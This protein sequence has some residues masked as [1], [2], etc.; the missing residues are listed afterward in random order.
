MK[1]LLF[2]LMALFLLGSSVLFAPKTTP[3]AGKFKDVSDSHWASREIFYLSGRG[4]ISGYP[5]GSFKPTEK[6]TRI[7]IAM[8]VQRE[9]KYNTANQPDPGLRDVPK[10]SKYHALV[11]AMMNNGLFTDIVKNGEF[12]LNQPVTRSEMAAILAK[13][14][15]LDG[16]S[17]KTFSDVPTGS[18][19]Y[20][21]I[22]AL[23]KNQITVGYNDGTFKPND[24]L[25][26]AQFSAM[27]AR[28]LNSAF[29]DS[30]VTGKVY[31][32]GWI[33]P[34]LKSSWNADPAVNYKTLQNELGFTNGGSRYDIQGLQGAIQVISQSPTSSYE[35]GI[36][37]NVWQDS[38]LTQSYRVPVV[39]KE[40]LKLYFSGDAT[41]VLGYLNSGNIPDD[42]TANGRKVHASVSGS[43]L[44]LEVGKLSNQPTGKVY[45]DGWVAPVLKSSWSSDPTKNYKTLQNELGFT[46][47]GKLYSIP[48]KTGA[49]QVISQGT[50]GSYEVA[51]Q[52]YVWKESALP[53][54]YRTPVVAKELFK[55][56]FDGEAT[57]VWNY[58]NSGNIPDS[59]TANGRSVQA[60][61]SSGRG[62]LTLKLGHKK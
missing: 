31:P 7:Q 40:L 36:K 22:Q 6:L 39:A 38:S 29:K 27:M 5:D 26:R 18:W 41:R 9:R 60:S 33:A 16:V 42:F 56:Y 19:S 24:T 50:G 58:L 1:K 3:A 43:G 59:F 25:T 11:A 53:Q 23:A 35:V 28:V 15:K 49:I 10:G 12:K 37:F 46:D 48:G 45:P 47:G 4:I 14:Y 17:G 54:S 20:P 21:Y 61:V 8:M 32:D 2:A 51:L 55:F 13:A 62:A 30:S 57:R 34:V 52:F 44:Y